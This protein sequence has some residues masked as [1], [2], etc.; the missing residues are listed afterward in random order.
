MHG[1]VLVH[2]CQ[3]FSASQ[4]TFTA[5]ACPGKCEGARV[6]GG[7]VG[8]R[9]HTSPGRLPSDSSTCSLTRAIQQPMAGILQVKPFSSSFGYDVF[10]GHIAGKPVH[11]LRRTNRSDPNF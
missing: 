5:K 10:W 11:A 3:N 8:S 2:W 1:G 4:V 7:G 9:V 6:G